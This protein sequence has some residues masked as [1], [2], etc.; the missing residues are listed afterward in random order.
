MAEFGGGG[1]GRDFARP[2]GNHGHADAA[3]VEVG[4]AAFEITYLAFPGGAVVAGE[5]DEGVIGDTEVVEG[6]EE[7]TD[8]GIHVLHHG[9]EAVL[10]VTD[11]GGGGIGPVG[12][13]GG[14]VGGVGDEPPEV[15]EEGAVVGREAF[16][17]VDGVVAVSI[18]E[19]FAVVGIGGGDV[20][21]VAEEDGA[22][23]AVD[24][25]VGTHFAADGLLFD[26]GLVEVETVL[27]RAGLIGEAAAGGIDVKS[28]EVP[29]A[30]VGG[31]VAGSTKDF[32]EG[33]GGL[34][35]PE[36]NVVEVLGD[37]ESKRVA[38]SEKRGAGW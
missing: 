16:D 34:G 13:G 9:A 30:D 37:I 4:F 31:D 22:A 3:V 17:E 5:D 7:L 29:F 35:E 19:V 28:A 36:I 2:A 27:A 32:G 23:L 25:A 33:E 14:F 12:L 10:V 21:I 6:G 24:S 1:T 20:L 15:E 38:A 11:T 18:G 8:L 26:F